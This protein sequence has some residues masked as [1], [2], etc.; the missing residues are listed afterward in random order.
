MRVQE[1]LTDRRII[2]IIFRLKS[3]SYPEAPV[4]VFNSL[5]EFQLFLDYT[6]VKH[7]FED[8]EK[9]IAFLDDKPLVLLCYKKK[10][11]NRVRISNVQ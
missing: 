10:R 5:R 9:Y 7:Y 3:F 2:Y 1:Y 6:N 11:K 8:D 4:L